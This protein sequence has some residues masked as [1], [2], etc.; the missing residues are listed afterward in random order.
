MPDLITTTVMIEGKTSKYFQDSQIKVLNNSLMQKQD[1]L[2]DL[3]KK[4][5]KLNE[6]KVTLI[7]EKQE[8]HKQIDAL[9]E[10]VS[11][12]TFFYRVLSGNIV[13]ECSHNFWGIYKR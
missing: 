12:S 8:M 6:E 3:E 7:K 10:Q 4:V 13:S 2:L 11:I 5:R 1:D 9:E